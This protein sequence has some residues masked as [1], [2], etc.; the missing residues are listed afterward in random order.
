MT[1]DRGKDSTATSAADAVGIVVQNGAHVARPPRAVAFVWGGKVRPRP[2][3]PFGRWKR[4]A[5]RP[6]A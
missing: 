3:L 5:V 6:E 1:I 2:S 4:K